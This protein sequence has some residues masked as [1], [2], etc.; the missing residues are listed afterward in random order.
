MHARPYCM[1]AQQWFER[2]S[3]SPKS[4]P[5]QPSAPSD[6]PQ[7]MSRDPIHKAEARGQGQQRQQT[8]EASRG[9]NRE[10]RESS[11][12]REQREQKAPISR[13]TPFLGPVKGC[14][15]ST[16]RLTA[17]TAGL[18]PCRNHRRTGTNTRDQPQPC[19][20]SPRIFLWAR[21]TLISIFHHLSS[22]FIF[23][24]PSSTSP[25]AGL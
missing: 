5:R 16:V 25:S 9:S 14:R 22:I 24:L 15:S 23:H 11:E 19:N 12:S 4:P 17:Y 1:Y 3:S 6:P 2:G 8:A 10:S 21:N 7:R 20:P 18:L 13:D